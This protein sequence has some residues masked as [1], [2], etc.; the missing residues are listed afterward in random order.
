MSH[1]RV[2]DDFWL[3]Q[4][5]PVK[6][7]KLAEKKNR[8]IR[9]F[10]AQFSKVNNFSNQRYETV[11]KI[12]T[13]L[14][15][16]QRKSKAE[17]IAERKRKDDRDK[18][19]RW[20]KLYHF[21]DMK[22]HSIVTRL[23]I[24]PLITTI[25]GTPAAYAIE[26][27]QIFAEFTWIPTLVFGE[28]TVHSHYMLLFWMRFLLFLIFIIHQRYKWNNYTLDVQCSSCRHNWSDLYL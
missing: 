21:T 10:G 27:A 11:R 17:E 13:S 7:I 2:S 20:T 23:K 3:K 18:E 12:C 25:I 9:I 15:V 4:Y 14:C 19:M 22:Y 28:L 24:Y 6:T 1:S 5:L 8:M 16:Q 26:A